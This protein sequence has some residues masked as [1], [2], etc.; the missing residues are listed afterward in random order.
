MWQERFN[1]NIFLYGTFAYYELTYMKILN[2]IVSFTRNLST[3]RKYDI[4]YIRLDQY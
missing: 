4:N 2:N 1:T 3:I